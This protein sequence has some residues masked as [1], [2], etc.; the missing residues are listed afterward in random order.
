MGFLFVELFL[1]NLDNNDVFP[2]YISDGRDL[3]KGLYKAF[4]SIHIWPQST[5]V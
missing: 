5:F 2:A 4:V 1:G 3:E